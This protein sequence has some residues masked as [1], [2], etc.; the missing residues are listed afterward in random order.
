MAPV[1]YVVAPVD[2]AV[3]VSGARRKHAAVRR[4]ASLA[5]LDRWRE[6]HAVAGAT[7]A[8]D[9]RAALRQLGCRRRRLS[10]ALRALLEALGS[11]RAVP[12]LKELQLLASS[13][14]S[15]FR[16]WKMEIPERPSLF[17]L[18]VRLV[19]CARLQRQGR[20]LEDACRESGFRSAA[21]YRRHLGRSGSKS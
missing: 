1:I 17:L 11:R 15:F 3:S 8:A 6:G 13:P 10:P 20:P 9:V 19:R 7:I 5:Q 16:A 21:D 12:H 18:R 2:V 14:R 4:F